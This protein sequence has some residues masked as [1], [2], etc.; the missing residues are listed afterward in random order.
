MK[1]DPDLIRAIIIAVSEAI[2]PDE[3]GFVSQIYPVDLANNKLSQY[4]RNEVLYW[5]HHLMDSGILVR[6]T[7]YTDEPMPHIKD[8]SISGYQF[9][10][11]V[12]KSSIWEEIRPQLIGLAISN[13][14]AF[15]QRTIEL[16][17]ALAS[18][19]PNIHL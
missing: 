7:K 14:P 16:V 5:I 6:G 11:N 10:E 18:Q 1:F 12:S 13:L 4:P 17:S 8:L 3:D 19:R 2:V 9:V 15:I